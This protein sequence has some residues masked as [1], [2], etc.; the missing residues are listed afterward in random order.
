MLEAM[1]AYIRR[2]GGGVRLTIVGEGE[3][4]DDIR[5]QIARLGLNGIVT[6]HG[7][8]YGRQ[9][10]SVYEQ[11]DLLLLTSTHESFGIVLI[12]AMTKGLPIVSV[13][14]PCVR[15]VVASGINGILSESTP[16][17]VADA[18]HTLLI[19][20]DLYEAV[21]MNNLERARS[22]GWQSIAKD[23]GTIYNSL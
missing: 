13:N 8:L 15:N 11:S 18:V 9:L 22:F 12:E 5:V 3:L 7:P 6:L 23:M 10:Q 2:H 17:A 21:S 14:I 19:D 1:A 16:D 20:H 4:K